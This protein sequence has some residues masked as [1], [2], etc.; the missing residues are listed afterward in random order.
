MIES[1][2][3]RRCI[4]AATDAY[5]ECALWSSTTDDG[6]PL[7]GLYS[8]TDIA[9]SAI[10][11]MRADVTDFLESCWADDVNLSTIEPEQLGHDFW[12][13]RN[14]HGAGFWDRGLGELGDELTKRAHAYGEAWLY[15]ADGTV[16][17][18]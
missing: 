16:Y 6:E 11:Q 14:H 12:L 1:L 13:T 7:D 8:V 3:T 5:I 10:E 9:E 4:E 2:A 17:T 15:I 18:L